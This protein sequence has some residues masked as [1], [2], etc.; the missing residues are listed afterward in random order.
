MKTQVTAIVNVQGGCVH[1]VYCPNPDI[2]FDYLMVD[3]DNE[4]SGIEGYE[5][6]VRALECADEEERKY[7]Y[8]PSI[9]ETLEE[10]RATLA[11]LRQEQAEKESRKTELDELPDYVAGR[12]GDLCGMDTSTLEHSL[13]IL[14]NEH[15]KRDNTTVHY[16]VWHLEDVKSRRPDLSDEQCR[17]VLTALEKSHNAEIGI[18]WDV[19][20]TI[21][22]DQ[23]PEP[24]NIH[25]LRA[26]Y[27]A[28]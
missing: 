6:L 24:E 16:N 9:Q 3:Y 18:N 8:Q 13:S 15:R 28:V 7:D 11:E 17:E 25:E 4:E 10:K 1:D 22:S 19:I 2:A 14:Q 27:D 5:E 23:F 21:A 20:D 12:V 26:N